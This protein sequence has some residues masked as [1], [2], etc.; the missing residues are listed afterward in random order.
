MPTPYNANKL[1][2]FL[3][4]EQYIMKLFPDLPTK[5]KAASKETFEQ[6]Q[7]VDMGGAAKKGSASY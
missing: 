1:R 4:I 7:S 3:E 2:R 6:R 5:K